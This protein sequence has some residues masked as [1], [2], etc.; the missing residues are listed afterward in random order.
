M[1]NNANNLFALFRIKLAL[2]TITPIRVILKQISIIRDY[3]DGRLQ[4][5]T[6]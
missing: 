1:Q 3:S 5:K 2:F 6:R 4:T